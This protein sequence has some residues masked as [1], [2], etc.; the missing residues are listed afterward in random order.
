MRA[1]EREVSVEDV[2]NWLEENDSDP[3]Y[4]VISMEEIAESVLN[5][6]QPGESSSSDS[7]DELA[8]RQKISQVRDCIH[9]LTQY[10]D[11]TNDVQGSHEHIR[12][13]R[14]LI[15]QK[16]YQRGKQLKL[17]PFFKPKPASTVYFRGLSQLH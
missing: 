4:R 14:D 9:T 16:Q 12:T 17:D 6:D 3:G 15:I 13:L 10:V 7:E 11:A 2:E 5:G 8:V 1:V